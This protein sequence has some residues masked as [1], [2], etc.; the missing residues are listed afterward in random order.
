MLTCLFVHVYGSSLAIVLLT[1]HP[2]TL[3]EPVLQANKSSDLETMKIYSGMTKLYTRP[4]IDTLL[5]T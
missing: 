3:A 2:G 1:M 5:H 4:V